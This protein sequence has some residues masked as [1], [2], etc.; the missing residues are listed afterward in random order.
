MS[1]VTLDAP[2][3]VHRPIAFARPAVARDVSYAHAAGSAPARALIRAVEAAT[4]RGALI[5]R[6]TG[7]EA[8]V[9]AG[10]DFWRVMMER[11]GIRLEVVRGSLGAIPDTGPLILV[12]NH[13]FGILDGLVM[14]HILSGVR[15]GD[16]RILAHQVFGRSEDLRRAV[17]PIDF[18]ATPEATAVNLRSRAEAVSHLRRGGAVG[19]FPGGTVSTAARVTGQ[20]M[21]PAWR[22]FTARMIAR[23]GASVVPVWF[24]GQNSRL[25][26]I[27][28]HLSPTLRVALLLREFKARLDRPVRLAIGEP[29]PASALKC[30][31]ADAKLTMDFLRRATYELSPKSLDAGLMGHEFEAHH[32][33]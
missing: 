18:A 11:F 3:P 4:G 17:L 26:Q 22:G 15:R 23:S 10:A 27:A 33:R 28:S 31:G 12:A 25:F 5:R 21:D 16:F 24:E 13:P 14:G 30:H 19:I 9:A 7:Y 20:P 1:F 8:E 2:L 32:K 6:A 29:I